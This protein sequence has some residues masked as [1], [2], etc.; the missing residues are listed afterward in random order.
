MAK[1]KLQISHLNYGELH[2]YYPIKFD[3]KLQKTFNI[4]NVPYL[5]L[6]N[7]SVG[8]WFLL[9]LFIVIKLLSKRYF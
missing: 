8:L 1:S 9:N 4:Y 2:F 5:T 3:T 7:S 6:E